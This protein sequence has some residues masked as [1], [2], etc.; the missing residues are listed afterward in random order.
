MNARDKQ[1]FTEWFG[2]ATDYAPYPFQPRFACETTLFQL[3]LPTGRGSACP[4]SFD[5]AQDWL[6][7]RGKGA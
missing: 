4:E 3:P 5:Y 1:E 2:H 6:R 7:R